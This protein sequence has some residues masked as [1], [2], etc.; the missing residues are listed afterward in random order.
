MIELQG[1]STLDFKV[2]SDTAKGTN[3]SPILTRNQTPEGQVAIVSSKLGEKDK[4]IRNLQAQLDEARKLHDQTVSSRK[5]RAQELKAQK[6]KQ[7]KASQDIVTKITSVIEKNKTSSLTASQVGAVVERASITKKQLEDAMK[8]ATK[9]VLESCPKQASTHVDSFDRK[10]FSEDLY[11]REDVHRL[12]AVKVSESHHKLL[13]DVLLSKRDRSPEKRSH[14]KRHKG[15]PRRKRRKRS[16][17]PSSGSESDSSS[18]SDGSN[19]SCSSHEAKARKKRKKK[20]KR[21]KY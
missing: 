3:S 8:K 7:D 15:K 13:S 9:S 16:P 6:I 14:K 17:S 2:A 5:A 12:A 20:K 1:S 18:S 19:S 10:G 11:A 21:R 4:E